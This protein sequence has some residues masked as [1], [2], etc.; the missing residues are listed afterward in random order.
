MQPPGDQLLPRSTLAGDEYRRAD[1]RD[2]GNPL[3]HLLEGFRFADDADLGLETLA[4]DKPPD[5]QRDLIGVD[6]LGEPLFDPQLGHQLAR[7][8][9]PP[10]EEGDN[11]DVPTVIGHGRDELPSAPLSYL[12]GQDQSRFIV[13]SRLERFTH[14]LRARHKPNL[15][16]RLKGALQSPGASRVGGAYQYS[17][18]L[19]SLVRLISAQ[20]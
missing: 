7:Y 11:R 14:V 3:N 19:A 9:L 15:I 18:H 4:I 10:S 16:V 13:H 1:R 6:R 8:Y 17:R 5:D 12:A 2:L 20:A